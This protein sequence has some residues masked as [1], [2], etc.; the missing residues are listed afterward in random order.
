[1]SQILTQLQMSRLNVTPTLRARTNAVLLA[2]LGPDG[3]AWA[4]ELMSDRMKRA[5]E[6]GMGEA[7]TLAKCVL[8]VLQDAG[9]MVFQGLRRDGYEEGLCYVGSPPSRFN[10]DGSKRTPQID[11]MFFVFI[12]EDRTIYTWG[13]ETVPSHQHND[14][15][16]GGRFLRRIR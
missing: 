10:A 14:P 2:G 7:T 6:H 11:D 5:A 15:T 16:F 3:S 9:A 13:W 1:M 4:F 12:N 8:Q